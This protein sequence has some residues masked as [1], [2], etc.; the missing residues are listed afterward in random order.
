MPKVSWEDRCT[1]IRWS[2]VFF[3]VDKHRVFMKMGN[4]KY[5]LNGKEQLRQRNSAECIE[6]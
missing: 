2:K 3:N 5:D 4:A 6:P 1:G